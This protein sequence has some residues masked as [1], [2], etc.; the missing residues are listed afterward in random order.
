[1]LLSLT[2]VN[3]R[4]S[5]WRWHSISSLHISYRLTSCSTNCKTHAMGCGASVA[6]GFG[7][8]DEKGATE[9]KRNP[10]VDVGFSRRQTTGS[11][12]LADLKSKFVWA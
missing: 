11:A 8:D 12:Q 6:V 7:L 2:S 4:S 5:L 1:M 9:S 10:K 3:R